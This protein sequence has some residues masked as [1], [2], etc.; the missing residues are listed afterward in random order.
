MNS[1][2]CVFGVEKLQFL[3]YEV[4]KEGIT[5][6]EEKVKIIRDFPQP[7]TKRKLCEFLGQHNFYHCFF[8]QICPHPPAN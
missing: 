3:G 7:I 6:L 1:T 4:S 2:K 5:L 8:T